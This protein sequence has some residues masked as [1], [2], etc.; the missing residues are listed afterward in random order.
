VCIKRLKGAEMGLNLIT[1]A[2]YKAYV[3]INSDNQDTAIDSLIPKV[4]ELVKS[5]CGVTF[6]DYVN[7]AKTE[8]FSGGNQ[9]YIFKETP[10]ISIVSAETSE[11][12]GQTYT[13][14]T[15][16]TDFVLDGEKG[17]LTSLA[18]DG[19]T[20][21]INGYKVSYFAGYETLPEDLKLALF[22]LLSFYMKNDA[23]SHMQKTTASGS[24]QLEYVTSAQFPSHIAR[25]LNL[26]KAS[27]D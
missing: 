5:Y 3:G 4:S 8:T 24:L 16:Y 11:D 2:E 18:T 21:K 27:W 22:D 12:Y 1:K 14:M 25:V 10:V 15:E 13:A 20:R 6:V 17:C 26:Y 23:I 19:F 7:D 9:D